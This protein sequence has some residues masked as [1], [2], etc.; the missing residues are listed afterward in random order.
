MQ[1]NGDQKKTSR[2]RL[3]VASMKEDEAAFME[4]ID[5]NMVGQPRAK[6]AALRLFRAIHNP[7]RDPN[8][9][10][11]S[12]ILAGESRTGKN[13]LV[14]LLAQWFH[15]DQKAL[16]KV[17]GGEFQERYSLNRLIGAPHGYIGHN[18]ANDPDR[19][20]QEGKKDT[21]AILSQ[22]NL[23]Q[24][25][26]GS[27]NDVIF[28]LLDEW[29]KMHMNV[30][31]IL[32]AGLDEGESTL[33][34]N[35]DINFRNVVLIL[36]SN[37]GMSELEQTMTRIGFTND[38]GRVATVEEVDSA[39]RK[40]FKDT[41]SP[42][43][44]NRIDLL[45]VY[46]S[47]SKDQLFEVVDLEFK[48]LQARILER[49]P[50]RIFMVRAGDEVKKHLLDRALS[51]E[52]GGL[53]NL[54]RIINEHVLEPIGGL[55]RHGLIN[56]GDV[57]ELSLS[58]G[59]IVYDKI[60]G[61][62]DLSALTAIPLIGE[63]KTVDVSTGYEL[64]GVEATLDASGILTPHSHVL[65]LGGQLHA[66]NLISLSELMFLQKAHELREMAVL[67]SPLMADYQIK[68][69]SKDSLDILTRA[70]F[71]VVRDLTDVMSVKVL[72]SETTYEP[73]YEVTIRVRALPGQMELLSLRYKGIDV[74]LLTE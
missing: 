50:D 37:M 4:F 63:N 19:R 52:E 40:A 49:L 53:A 36:T 11:F 61:E 5:A 9:P 15:G 66:G 10:I 74:T 56:S 48:S 60:E 16:V 24:S 8:R 67:Q 7:L 17:N 38:A 46:D 41:S 58:D 69:P 34:N 6:L 64:E 70:A 65:H 45:V 26:Q 42:E 55:A 13:H 2:V 32:L 25:K 62:A 68:I 27:S 59:R 33:A 31:N 43:F 57:V 72:S 18:D 22:H 44:R 12:V 28:L 30:I 35:E 23:D 14:R 29:E 71:V 54:K 47:L 51:D 39:V 3:D 73:P 20:P 21:S 1:A